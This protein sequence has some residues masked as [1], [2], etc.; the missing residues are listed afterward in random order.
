MAT[1]VINVELFILPPAQRPKSILSGSTE[2]AVSTNFLQL[3]KY[4]KN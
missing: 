1:D 2:L 4:V 3:K